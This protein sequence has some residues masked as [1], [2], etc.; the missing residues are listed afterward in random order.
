MRLQALI[1]A[2][3]GGE[4]QRLP[5]AAADSAPP[6]PASRPPEDFRPLP[7]R[8]A[9]VRSSTTAA[10]PAAAVAAPA[11]PQPQLQQHA[12]RGAPPLSPTGL[13]AGIAALLRSRHQLPVPSS[14]GPLF[15]SAG[16]PASHATAAAPAAA[17]PLTAAYTARAAR[18]AVATSAVAASGGAMAATV[19]SAARSRSVER[20]RRDKPRAKSPPRQAVVAAEGRADRVAAVA[21]PAPASKQDPPDAGAPDAAVAAGS[22]AFAATA[23]AAGAVAGAD[24]GGAVPGGSQGAGGAPMPDVGRARDQTSRGRSRSAGRGGREGPGPALEVAAHWPATLRSSGDGSRWVKGPCYPRHVVILNLC[25]QTS[26]TRCPSPWGLLVQYQ[27]LL[28]LKQCAYTHLH[29]PTA[30]SLLDACAGPAAPAPTAG[31]PL[32]PPWCPAA[33]HGCTTRTM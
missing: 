32:N 18:R 16:V 7:P 14:L 4:P 28:K 15:P 8:S 17:A 24:G 12:P 13:A 1:A 2:Q 25:C 11:P 20:A 23:E 27:V 21:A 9:P 5:D 31:R 22:P 10:A 19:A 29:D 26:R 3:Q 33:R 30:G 6:E